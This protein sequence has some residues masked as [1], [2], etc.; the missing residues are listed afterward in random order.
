LE[1][2]PV[3]TILSV[4]E[5]PKLDK[6]DDFYR[7]FIASV[8]RDENDFLHSVPIDFLVGEN[9]VVSIS[10]GEVDYFEEFREREKGETS[11]GKLDAESFTASLLDLHIVSY[12]RALEDVERRVDRMDDRI[13]KRDLEDEEFLQEMVK[14]RRDVSKLRRWFLPHRDVFYFDCR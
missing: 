10:N 12:F 13:L 1:N 2:V 9:F 7:F 6:F 4:S 14:L 11:L 5:R 3:K 8:K